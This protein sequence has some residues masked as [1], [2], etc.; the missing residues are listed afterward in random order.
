MGEIEIELYRDKAPISVK[1]F[2]NYVKKGFYNGTIFHRVMP[3]FMIQGGGFTRSMQQKLTDDPIKN[4]ADNGLSNKR[5]T[6]AMARTQF[7]DSATAQ[8]FINLV[9]NGYL[10]HKSELRFGYCVFGKVVKGMDVVDRIARVQT[11]TR[12]MHANVPVSPVM[13]QSVTV[14]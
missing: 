2:L 10:D 14:K 3:G 4:E 5:G 7:K 12:G 1:N 8:F 11:Q 6:V 13:I 9:N